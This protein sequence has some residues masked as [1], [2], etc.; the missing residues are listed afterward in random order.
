MKYI[1]AALLMIVGHVVQAQQLPVNQVPTQFSTG[2]F[3][4]GWHKADSGHV[5]AVRDTNFTPR[6]AGTTILWQN[7]GV[8]TAQWVWTGER[9][10]KNITTI[11]PSP[12]VWGSI[13]GTLSN[14][15]DLQNAL[16]A[17]LNITDTTDK[18]VYDIY[19]RGDSVFF[20]KGGVEYFAYKD[21]TGSGG[22]GTVT[23]VDLSMPSAF[24]VSGNPIT[25]NGTINVSGAGTTLQ[26]IRGN[27]TLATMDTSA[28]PS[29]YLKTRSLFS[30]T[31]P[32]QYNSTTGAFSIL[33]ATTTQKGVA[34][35]NASDFDVSSGAVS[36]TDLVTA[37]S[38]TNCDI[39]FDSKGRA[40]A[41]SN[42]A[43]TGITSLNGLT[44][45]VQVFAF[46]SSGTT[47]NFVSSAG[48]HTL[49]IPLAN[50][51]GVTSGTITKTEYD[52]FSNKLSG[53][54]NVGSGYRLVVPPS[55]PT[56]NVRGI[57][58][59]FGIVWDSTTNS[60]GLTAN[61]DST[62]GTGVPTYH[63]VDSIAGAT[64]T[65]ALGSGDTLLTADNEIKR[66]NTDATITRSTNAN[67]ILLGADTTNY[68]ST[69]AKLRDTAAAIRTSTWSTT[70]NAG[71]TGS[72]FIGTTDAAG[73]IIRTNNVPRISVNSNANPF[74]VH[75]F[76]LHLYDGSLG[77]GGISMY[78][79]SPVR[80]EIRFG[81]FGTIRST[82]N[83]G[84]PSTT[85]LTISPGSISS[86]S[87]TTN[88][89]LISGSIIPL[90]G[91]GTLNLM[92]VNGSID[93]MA[94]A[95][96]GITRSLYI[97][98]TIINAADHRAFEVSTGKSV[99]NGHVYLNANGNGS[100][101]SPRYLY[102]NGSIGANKDS[103]PLVTSITSEDIQL[104]D[105]TTGQLKRIKASDLSGGGGSADSSTFSTNFRRD[106]AIAN[107]RG[108]IE[109][110]AGDALLNGQ[111]NVFSDF[112]TFNAGTNYGL[113]VIGHI[114]APSPLDT[115]VLVSIYNTGSGAGLRATNS[116][117][118]AAAIT[119]ANIGEGPGVY[120]Y[121]ASG[122]ALQATTSTA[123]GDES[124]VFSFTKYLQ[125][126]TDTATVGTFI[127]SKTSS[128]QTLSNN[129]AAALKFR[130]GYSGGLT[131]ESA[132]MYWLNENATNRS[133]RFELHTASNNTL[134]RKLAIHS[135]GKFTFDNY[136]SGTFT[137]TAAKYLAVEAD[138][139]I[140]EV[141]APEGSADSSTFSTNYR[142]DSA[143]ANVRGEIEDL[144]NAETSFYNAEGTGDTLLVGVSDTEAYLKRID[145]IAGANVTIT[146]ASTDSTLKKYF[147]VSTGASNGQVLFDNSGVFGGDAALTY[148]SS[149]DVLTVPNISG[150]SGSDLTLRALSPQ[151]ISFVTNSIE[152]LAINNSGSIVFNS[153]SNTISFP[154]FRADVGGSVLADMDGSGALSWQILIRGTQSEVSTSS[155]T[156]DI[157]AND[158]FDITE[159]AENITI[160]APT[161]SYVIPNFRGIQFRIK[162]DGTARTIT[163]NSVYNA[164]SDFALPTSIE[165]ETFVIYFERN[166]NTS[167]WDA[168]GLTTF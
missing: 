3:K 58:D 106:T 43:S 121:T 149:T 136:G 69:V 32:L 17:K 46:G 47:P 56:G 11:T 5:F 162:G 14:Q 122:T 20:A 31:S 138:G 115:N 152:R 67:Q 6:Y 53:I 78:S 9:W 39:T 37:G 77:N 120:A 74:T 109:E 144:A 55:G 110:L 90:S 59:G 41:F 76:G 36:L 42:G 114:N 24:S 107:V 64:I 71:M 117:F 89:L 19:R 57:Y 124:Q 112:T 27:G 33:D 70:G 75:E 132:R 2:Y 154:T 80:N 163:W 105:T 142:R 153:G 119:G 63:Y 91:T 103:M 16:D 147:S 94:G 143:I 61:I 49:N 130:L 116:G 35:F 10:I 160:N 52:I 168:V 123:A 38:C 158:N 83:V 108:E 145:L 7:S 82:S 4:Q 128:G 155:F 88:A 113:K 60:D 21:S 157:D 151:K 97:N 139:D 87:G 126:A 23:S 161:S 166:T 28:I 131:Y 133:T 93:Q 45:S 96:T 104:I 118:G 25:S 73:F 48:T 137:G 15:T 65:N 164:P 8:D 30:G 127:A 148:N 102:V 81:Q 34:S 68:V 167:Q 141:D 85:P 86:T 135:N 72:N 29:F 79:G 62:R 150:P 1:L 51:S 101:T 18:W 129:S 22:T 44:A 146:D 100:N 26:Y 159:L 98:P 95:A 111:E 13:T 50:Q 66:I 92:T 99:F 125:D 40:I 134:A 165:N 140:I 156:P 84:N 12:T 54:Q